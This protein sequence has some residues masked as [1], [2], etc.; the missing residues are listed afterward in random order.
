M[1][2]EPRP[3]EAL[4]VPARSIPGGERNRRRSRVA[5]AAVVAA[6]A[7][8]IVLAIAPDGRADRPVARA[9]VPIAT[10]ASASI[11]TPNG[12]VRSPEG[13]HRPTR[14]EVLPTL[15]NHELP[16]AGRVAV[17]I[18]DG[19]DA[20]VLDWKPGER[21]LS[22]RRALPEAFRSGEGPQVASLAPNGRA[23]VS[24]SITSSVGRDSSLLATEDGVAWEGIGVT[25]LTG[26][27]WTLDGRRVAMEAGPNE[28]L[29]V[30]RRSGT[31]AVEHRL[32]LDERAIASAGPFA[33]D[34]RH[35]HPVGFTTDGEFLYGARY[36]LAG[37]V[38]AALKVDV[39]SGAIEPVD[40]FPA[41]GIVD[42]TPDARGRTFGFGP[43]AATPGGPPS[44]AVLNAD[45][46]SAFHVQAGVVLGA[47]WVE[48]GQLLLL[49]VDGLPFPT[50]LQL[51]AVDGD[52]SF[53]EPLFEAKGVAGGAL[54]G[55]RDGFV[56]LA[57]TVQR[58]T[59]RHELVVV[60]LRD[61][62]TAGLPIDGPEAASIVASRVMP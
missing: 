25:G 8:G 11:I 30:D 26:V 57:V 47:S 19:T 2:D 45:G 27:A 56:A 14:I 32:T 39:E 4:D 10:T 29:I 58:P 46:S 9:S 53:G 44:V 34:D 23:L 18:R 49:V 24:S 33:G 5:I 41:G 60:R 38:R 50:R 7:T 36:G 28:W 51:I 15:P 61:G 42:Y 55:V 52:G 31:R 48:G 17:V 16:G 40:A 1:K 43:N 13:T 54:I 3:L 22:S 59:V 6:V 62:A 37:D 21:E 35:I 20:K 12:G